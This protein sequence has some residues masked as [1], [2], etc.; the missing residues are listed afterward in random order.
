MRLPSGSITRRARLALAAL[1]LALASGPAGAQTL[2]I[3]LQ[4]DPDILDPHRARTF[5]GRIVFTSLCDKLVDIT[6][7]L[8][9]VPS[10]ATGWSVS[11]DRL[12]LTFELREG[13]LFHDGTPIDA[14]AVKA[15]LDRARAL[16]D[17]LRKSELAS[18]ESVEVVDEGTVAL[19]L[20][21][22]DAALL[23]QLSD[24]AGMMMSPASFENASPSAAP[25]CS[26][27]YRFVERVQNDRIVLEK[28]P[29]H[30]DAQSYL[31]ERVVFRAIPDNTVRFANLQS[32]D[33]QL[34][35]RLGANDTEAAEAAAGITVVPV[36]GLGY[37]A[38]AFNLRDEASPLADA[39]VRRALDLAI[40]RD[41]INQVVGAG[42]Y[43]PAYQPFPP[44]SFAHE[45]GLERAGRDVEGAKALLAEAGHERVAF[46]LSFGNNTAMQQVLELVQAMAAEA[47][48]DISLR[49][50]EFAALQG[51]L[52]E[53]RFEVAQS[54]WSGRVDPDGNIHQHVTCGGSLNDGAYCNEAV[55]RLLNEARETSDPAEREPLY[56]EAQAILA[57]D[58]PIVYLYYLP[59][60]FAHTTRLEG[61]VGYPDG[62]I[63][64]R[65]VEMKL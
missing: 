33:L 40:D 13:A 60:P 59:Y 55:D 39:R 2:S 4:D 23:S 17:S 9:L 8:E 45:E 7:E 19:H 5:V 28:F 64:L 11:E 50:T 53:G 57:A 24:R 21:A 29:E 44:A 15:N 36:T 3:G 58:K 6:P 43:Q 1:G 31:V 20:S 56:A 47:G 26:G 34:I 30:W 10:L 48:F 37:Q 32:G 61:F 63:R 16:P 42:T 38:L 52:R 35:E 62:M 12:T 27:P 54:G 51:E 49:P 22:P 65:G 14:A 18:V 46:E 41:I 25:V